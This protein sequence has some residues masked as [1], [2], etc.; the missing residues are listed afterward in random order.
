MGQNAQNA[1]KLKCQR[2]TEAR[3]VKEEKPTNPRHVPSFMQGSWEQQCRS[4]LRYRVYAK[5]T[6][7]QS[8]E[9]AP[10]ECAEGFS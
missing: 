7:I 8:I 2:M 3:P 10:N 9:I 5:S 1:H 4:S 6:I